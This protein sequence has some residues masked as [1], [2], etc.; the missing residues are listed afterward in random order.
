VLETGLCGTLAFREVL[1]VGTFEAPHER[2]FRRLT[3]D[4][5]L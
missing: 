3:S 1:R 4:G 5:C 2:E